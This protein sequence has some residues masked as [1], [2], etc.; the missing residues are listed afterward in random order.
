MRVCHIVPSLEERH[1]GPSKSVRA[2]ANHVAQA[3]TEVTLLATDEAGD[4][5][6]PADDRAANRSSAAK[7]CSRA[8]RHWTPR[9]G[10]FIRHPVARGPVTEQSVRSTMSRL[11]PSTPSW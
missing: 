10:Q 9:P 2:L 3:G 11:T 8:P 4:T 6:T 1:G 7:S 5:F